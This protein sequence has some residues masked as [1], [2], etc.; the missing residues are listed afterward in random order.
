MRRFVTAAVV[1]IRIEEVELPSIVAADPRR[2]ERTVRAAPP[3]EYE[4]ERVLNVR[5]REG[6]VVHGPELLPRRRTLGQPSRGSRLP[7]R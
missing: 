3:R 7:R 4:L 6:D 1:A 5:H 2:S